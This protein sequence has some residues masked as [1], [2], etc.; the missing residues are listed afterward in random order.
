MLGQ[1]S[2][3]K[4][5]A[6]VAVTSQDKRVLAG[7][8]IT[9]AGFNGFR[10]LGISHRHRA[11]SL[12]IGNEQLHVARFYQYG[13]HKDLAKISRQTGD[14]PQ[15]RVVSADPGPDPDDT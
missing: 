14:D 15:E 4:T 12:E 13:S 1:A 2:Q 3:A 7:G 6:T 5:P 10:F 11:V 8:C 9:D